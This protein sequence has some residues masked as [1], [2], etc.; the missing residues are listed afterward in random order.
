MCFHIF[1]IF[2]FLLACSAIFDTFRRPHVCVTDLNSF[3]FVLWYSCH[4][5]TFIFRVRVSR[6]GPPGTGK[7]LLARACAAKTEATFMKISAPA[8]VQMYIG[9]GA[10]MVRDAFALAREKKPTIIFVCVTILWLK[11]S[12]DSVMLS[13]FVGFR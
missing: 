2:V 4:D 13:F 1:H 6:F 9:D 10:K 8:L 12:Y 3:V 7:T 5:V 11:K